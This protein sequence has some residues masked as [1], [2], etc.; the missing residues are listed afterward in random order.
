MEWLWRE[1]LRAAAVGTSGV[2]RRSLLSRVPRALGG[3][4][5]GCRGKQ[6]L[7]RQ[8]WRTAGAELGID[9]P[10]VA[11]IAARVVQPEMQPPGRSGSSS[12]GSGSS[13]A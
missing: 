2:R 1:R 11:A 5:R 13:D 7:G 4:G 9:L 10:A 3:R 6:Q 12:G 8:R